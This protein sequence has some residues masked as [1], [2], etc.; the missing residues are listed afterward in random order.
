MIDIDD[1]EYLNIVNDILGNKTF[2]KLKVQEHHG[3]SR[4]EHSLKV[5]YYSYK[6][7]KTL[8]LDY[9]KTA[10]AGLLH[11]FFLSPNDQ[12]FKEKVISTLNHSNKAVINSAK[13][14]GICSKERDM[15]KS[16]M[17]PLCPSIPKYAESW[18]IN[19]T[20]KYVAIGEYSKKFGYRLSYATNLM[21]LIL[22]N[23]IR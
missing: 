6:I 13:Y 18:I 10:R 23:Y 5:S 19:F 21:M 22:I 3:V 1:N 2:N 15:I 9:K 20:D 11:D 16:H 17:F 12:S 14:F 7:S 8:K 4:F